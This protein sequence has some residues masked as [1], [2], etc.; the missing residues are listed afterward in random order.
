MLEV[1]WNKKMVM[2]WSGL[3]A[4][5]SVKSHK[6]NFTHNVNQYW[7]HID[8]FLNKLFMRILICPCR[9]P[10]LRTL[11]CVIYP[12]NFD[13]W[14]DVHQ[15][16]SAVNFL[17]SRLP[18]QSKISRPVSSKSWTSE[19]NSF[20]TAPPHVKADRTNARLPTLHTQHEY[21][22]W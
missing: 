6:V 19:I 22:L 5:E 12:L 13:G 1:P 15:T 10:N 7:G 8:L 16:V 17:V 18:V 14:S 9:S 11:K 20:G 21:R 3:V 2:A 4:T